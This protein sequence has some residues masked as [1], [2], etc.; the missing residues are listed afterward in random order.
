TS[1]SAK[2][3]RSARASWPLTET[4]L[5]WGGR[6]LTRLDLL[7]QVGGPLWRR[8]W[9]RAGTGGFCRGAWP[10]SWTTASPSSRQTVQLFERSDLSPCPTPP[11][12]SHAFSPPALSPP[13]GSS[14]EV[15]ATHSG[16]GDMN[17]VHP[18]EA[19]AG[20]SQSAVIL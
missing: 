1:H 9:R 14:P 20:V 7:V 18:A 3:G 19:C 8:P 2:S 13:C 5:A 16:D 4:R 12:P 17:R 15:F 10:P 6:H 11:P